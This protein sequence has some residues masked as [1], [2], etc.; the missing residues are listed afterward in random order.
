MLIAGRAIVG[1]GAGFVTV[2]TI[3]LLNEIV[4]EVALVR[5]ILLSIFTLQVHP[6]LRGCTSFSVSLVVY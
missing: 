4:S 1:A 2:S 3:C 6:R 5:R